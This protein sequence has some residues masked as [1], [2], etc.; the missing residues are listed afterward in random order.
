MS[1]WQ[2]RVRRRA[3]RSSDAGYADQGAFGVGEVTRRERER[4]A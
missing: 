3:E 1:R 2:T 4:S